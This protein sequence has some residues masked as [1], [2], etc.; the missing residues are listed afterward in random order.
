MKA[1]LVDDDPNTLA[2]INDSIDWSSYNIDRVF[3]A[4]NGL[5][6][7]EMI[8]REKPEIIFSDIEMPQSDGLELLIKV[9]ELYDRMPAFV[10]LTCHDSFTMAQT[11]IRYGVLDYLLKPFQTDE[12]V[13]VLNRA[14]LVAE[15]KAS[16]AA[17]VSW[18]QRTPSLT[19]EDFAVQNFINRVF[20]RTLPSDLVELE[21]VVAQRGIRF[22]LS[23]RYYIVYLG[24]SAQNADGLDADLDYAF[25]IKNIAV[26]TMYGDFNYTLTIESGADPYRSVVM[27]LDQSFGTKDDVRDKG[28]RLV[29]LVSHFLKQSLFCCVSDAITA[30]RFADTKAAM[31]AL[32]QKEGAFSSKVMQVEEQT[33]GGAA[34]GNIITQETLLATLRERRKTDMINYIK[35]VL[36]QYDDAGELT[37]SLLQLLHH[38]I[39]QAFYAYLFSSHIEVSKL[40]QNAVYKTLHDRAA[41]SPID[42]MKFVNYLYDSSI[43]Q[44]NQSVGSQTIV[45]K[46]KRYIEDHFSSEVTREDIAGHVSLAPNYLSKVF[47]EEAGMSIR[48]YIN[49]CRI[50]EAKRLMSDT[51]LTVTEIS[52]AVG[53]DNIPYFSTV[54]K[55]FVHETPS[56]WMRKVR[57]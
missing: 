20:A 1:M 41:Y 54:F 26:E 30:N 3:T 49:Q 10:F 44:I 16:D 36:K 9:S 2:R 46:A 28:K 24:F 52:L 31:D 6:A 42:M 17:E 55:K 39:L 50:E 18:K 35:T 15:K 29:E 19:D 33:N 22:D 45:A 27:L 25:A 12:L 43:S 47:S 8:Q 11:A 4:L 56:D 32:Y 14:V 5:S 23:K 21:R 57:K 7:F 53:F 37:A 40:F 51:S 48:D 38:E 34:H 13:A